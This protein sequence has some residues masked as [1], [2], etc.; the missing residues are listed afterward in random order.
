[1]FSQEVLKKRNCKSVLYPK[2]IIPPSYKKISH[3][4][5]KKNNLCFQVWSSIS[6]FF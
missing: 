3:F 5:L 1:M 2:K 6:R 4:F